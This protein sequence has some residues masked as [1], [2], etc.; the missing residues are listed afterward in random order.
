MTA[1]AF[2]IGN[3]F[4]VAMTRSPV[5]RCACSTTRAG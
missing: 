1:Y 2:R 4:T 3:V 5:T